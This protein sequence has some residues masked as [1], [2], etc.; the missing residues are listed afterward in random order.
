MNVTP[1][2]AISPTVSSVTFPEACTC[3]RENEGGRQLSPCAITH[4]ASDIVIVS[5]KLNS[6][7]FHPFPL[8]AMRA[9][10]RLLQ[11]LLPHPPLLASPKDSGNQD[12]HNP[13][14]IEYMQRL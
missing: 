11:D 4:W 14:T 13:L 2:D 12:S 1:V 3:T 6:A 9:P 10:R 5:Y 7:S 8:T